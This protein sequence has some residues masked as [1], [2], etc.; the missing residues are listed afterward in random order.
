MTH[1]RSTTPTSDLTQA[2]DE[3]SAASSGG[4]P[5]LFAFGL[6]LLATGLAGFWLPVRTAALIA[7]FQ[8]NA[9][10]PLAFWLER[11]LSLTRM[12]P[13]NPL[14]ALSTQLA[15]S[16]IAALP[17]VILLYYLAPWTVPAGLACMGAAH[18]V[19][20]AWLQR[21][22]VYLVVAVVLPVGAMGLT[23]V[24]WQDA[25]PWVLIYIA[26]VYWGAA[27]LLYRRSRALLREDWQPRAA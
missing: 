17:A 6:T 11:R 23:A 2:L 10:L 21:S 3:V 8:G 16:Q 25:L 5:F 14:H 22:R 15:M 26:A 12:A 7:L 19:P 13:D 27:P 1:T 9:A 20:Y 24:L 4:A 18:F